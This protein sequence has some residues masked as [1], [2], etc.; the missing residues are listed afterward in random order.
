MP[1]ACKTKARRGGGV[2]I[3]GVRADAT[4]P[5]IRRRVSCFFLGGWRLRVQGLG[6][7]V[8][9]LRLR[10][11]I[12]FGRVMKRQ[13]SYK[14]CRQVAIGFSGGERNNGFGFRRGTAG[15]A[16]EALRRL[17]P[18]GWWLR[19]WGRQSSL[20]RGRFGCPTWLAAGL[21]VGVAF[22]LVASDHFHAGL[23]GLRGFQINFWRDFG[24]ASLQARLLR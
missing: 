15:E 11:S 22:S 13:I 1:R 14:I 4:E 23:R 7:C 20:R 2:A 24:L 21:A 6:V 19:A 17:W 8:G 5:R 16:W 3:V 18:R 10:S 12:G 9:G